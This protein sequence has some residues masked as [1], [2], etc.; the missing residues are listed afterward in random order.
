MKKVLYVFMISLIVLGYSCKDDDNA[1]PIYSVSVKLV[2][3]DKEPVAKDVKVVVTNKTND[4]KT[5]AKTDE[6]GIAKFELTAGTYEVTASEKRSKD[7]YV[8]LFNGTQNITV[9]KDWKADVPVEL[10]LQQSK[11]S[12]I[13]VK[14][15]FVGGTPKDDGSGYFRYDRYVIL[16]NNSD[17]SAKITKNF[18]LA[19]TM[20]YNSSGANKYMVGGKLSYE[21]EGWI[22]AGQAVWYFNKEVVVEPY[23]QVVIALANA[24]DNTTTYSQ[25]INFANPKYYCTYDI[26][27]FSHKLTYVSPSA[28]IPTD[29]YLKALAYGA[30][31]AWTLS[32][33]CPGFFLFSTKDVSLKDFVADKSK[34]DLYGGSKYL[35]SKKVPVEWIVDGVEAFWYGK[36]N[37][38]RLTAAVDAGSVNH[39]SKLGYSI[40]RNVDKDATE[41]IEGNKEKLVYNYAGGTNDI[42]GGTTDPSG[43]DAEASIKKG[44]KIIYKD[45]NNSSNDFHQRKKAS[46]RTN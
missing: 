38:K 10:N 22:P 33:V 46:L 40:Y 25:S 7:F 8:A 24:V 16:Y 3:P 26:D 6:N 19:T 23:E 1:E 43:I 34:D 14:E 31:S 15:L 21:A 36:T 17:L 41:A 39:T 29:N 30:G 4:N 32:Q 37:T 35:V 42:E 5:E 28:Q 13:I 18:A 2:Y 44:A 45:T 27:V 20:P 9:S 11:S 12:Q